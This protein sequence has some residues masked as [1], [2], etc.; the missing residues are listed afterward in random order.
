MCGN[1]NAI[2][3]NLEMLIND[4]DK[5]AEGKGAQFRGAYS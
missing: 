3:M 4:L 2:V 5:L 1:I